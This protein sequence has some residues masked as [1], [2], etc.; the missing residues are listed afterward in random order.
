MSM[1]L[2]CWQHK[3]AQDGKYRDLCKNLPWYS[4]ESVQE[5][6]YLF[7]TAE[8]MCDVHT[9]FDWFFIVFFELIFQMVFM[10]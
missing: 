4:A 3:R 2:R 8:V 6:K 5:V 7:D 10:P 9:E 1:A